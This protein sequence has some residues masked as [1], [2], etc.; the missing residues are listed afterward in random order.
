MTSFFFVS[1]FFFLSESEPRHWECNFSVSNTKLS[2]H[3]VCNDSCT[4]SGMLRVSR[5]H[6]LFASLCVPD[7]HTRPWMIR[8]RKSRKGRRKE[9]RG[10]R[11]YRVCMLHACLSVQRC[12]RSNQNADVGERKWSRRGGGE[13]MSST[14]GASSTRDVNVDYSEELVLID[15]N[16]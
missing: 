1:F 5:G 4:R 12:N 6:H 15:A 7:E 8:Q 14:R 11:C 16:V 10:E 3:T 9:R 2:A 13:S